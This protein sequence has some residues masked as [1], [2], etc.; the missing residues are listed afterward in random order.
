LNEAIT[1]AIKYAFPDGKNGLI[2]ISLARTAPDRSLLIISDNGIGITTNDDDKKP[3]SLGMSLMKGLSEDLDGH[4]S[5]E[6]NNGT[7]IKITFLHE[8]AVKRSEPLTASLVA[9][10]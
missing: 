1:N 10:N 8:S 9:N 2:F 3:G 6:N 4:F 7:T 5:I